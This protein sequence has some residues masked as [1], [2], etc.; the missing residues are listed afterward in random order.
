MALF[1]FQTWHPPHDRESGLQR[2]LQLLADIRAEMERE[3][4]GLRVR[5]D[6]VA[7]DAAFSQ[8]LLED[9]GGSLGLSSKLRRMTGTMIGHTERIALLQAQMDFVVD[10]EHKAD[11]FSKGGAFA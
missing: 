5:Y 10:L 3:R 8:Q 4:N 6:K 7:G 2:L 11:T 1:D 9:E